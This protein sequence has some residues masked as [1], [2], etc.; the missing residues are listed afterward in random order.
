MYT[1][2]K[3]QQQW[4]FNLDMAE[5]LMKQGLS[6]MFINPWVLLDSFYLQNLS[7][8]ELGHQLRKY[9]LL[10]VVLLHASFDLLCLL[11]S[12]NLLVELVVHHVN[13]NAY[14]TQFIV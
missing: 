9:F 8:V 3:L 2:K 10:I 11:L 4:L 1:S 5:Y 7:L 13:V 6:Q 14:K 12:Q